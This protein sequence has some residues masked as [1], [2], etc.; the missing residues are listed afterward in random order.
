MKQPE[1][2]DKVT[3][4]TTDGFK[5]AAI[6]A[7]GDDGMLETDTAGEIR[8]DDNISLQ[9]GGGAKRPGTWDYAG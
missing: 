2:G 8:V 7:I 3:I 9:P 5:S 1:V 6:T 4:M